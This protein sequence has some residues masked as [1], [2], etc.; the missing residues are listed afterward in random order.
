VK[1]DFFDAYFNY[2]EFTEPPRI[3]H[4][5]VAISGIATVLGRNPVLPHGHFKLYHNQYIMLVGGSGS[6]KSTAI[7]IM[8]ELLKESGYDTIAAEKTSKEKFL[9]DLQDGLFGE[10]TSDKEVMDG[11]TN[12][13]WT[14][15]QTTRE[16]LIAADEFNDFVGNGNI[17]FLSLLGSLWDYDGIYKARVKNS[18]SVAIPFPTINLLA[19]NTSDRLASA[20]PIDAIGQGFTSRILLIHGERSEKKFPFPPIP[21]QDAKRKILD[22]L[23][24]IKSLCRGTVTIDADASE[25]LS[26]LYNS[27]QSLEDARF[28]AYSTRRFGHLLKL[29]IIFAAARCSTNITRHDCLYCNTVLTLAESCMPRTFGEFGK[30]RNSSTANK[31]VEYLLANDDKPR[32]I[33]EI[34][35]AVAS[36][37]EKVIDLTNILMNLDKSGKIQRAGKDLGWLPKRSSVVGE[38]TEFLDWSLLSKEELSQ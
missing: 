18:Q 13:F 7:K 10:E 1:D 15:D 27:W 5:W 26:S 29:T 24:Q 19:G 17:D 22:K 12:G 21:S 32:T 8:K 36:D 38:N 30:A 2:T 33:G 28:S 34:Y 23:Q 31:V 20:I 35:K 14:E 16:C 6:R 25:F 4:R 11:N 9:L 37:L 3:Y